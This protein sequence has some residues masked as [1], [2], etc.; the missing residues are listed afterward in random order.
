VAVQQ[1]RI[2]L[3]PARPPAIPFAGPPSNQSRHPLT[4][5]RLTPYAGSLGWYAVDNSNLVTVSRVAGALLAVTHESPECR[6]HAFSTIHRCAPR[7]ARTRNINCSLTAGPSRAAY[8]RRAA[9]QL[10]R[11]SSREPNPRM[12]LLRRTR[13]HNRSG[14]TWAATTSCP[15][16]RQRAVA[17]AT[18]S[19]RGRASNSCCTRS[20]AT[21]TRLARKSS[22][23]FCAARRRPRP[24]VVDYVHRRNRRTIRFT[25][26]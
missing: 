17:R 4:Q 20:H 8:L 1:S 2:H 26:T 21:P 11:A 9:P 7:C 5:R 24:N 6:I 13:R 25:A 23:A 19:R 10:A 3:T 22:S 18:S 14:V 15:T 12:S 16:F